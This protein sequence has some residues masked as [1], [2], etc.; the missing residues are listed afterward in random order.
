MLSSDWGKCCQNLQFSHNCSPP[1]NFLCTCVWLRKITS[2]THH[3]TSWNF[4]IH[5]GL[6]IWSRQITPLPHHPSPRNRAVSWTSDLT[7][8]NHPSTIPPFS[9]ESDLLIESSGILCGRQFCL[10]ELYPEYQNLEELCREF[11]CK[12]EGYRL[13]CDVL[14]PVCCWAPKKR[15]NKQP[16]LSL[17]CFTV[18]SVL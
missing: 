2:P 10:S 6:Q 13:V 15:N 14:A 12:P 16:L 7:T 4:E 18:H 5:C 3:P 8:S 11:S 1:T 9:S 17:Q